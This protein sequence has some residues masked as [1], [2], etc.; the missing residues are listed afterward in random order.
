MPLHPP[1]ELMMY[2]YVC[3]MDRVAASTA[4][5][6]T[7]RQSDARLGSYLDDA[8]A[9]QDKEFKAKLERNKKLREG[10]ITST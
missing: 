1:V 6:E 2:G 10:R 5:L 7:A 3:M 8:S 9:E 4:A